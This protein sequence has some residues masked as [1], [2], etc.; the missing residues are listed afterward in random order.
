MPKQIVI[1]MGMDYWNETSEV[2]E[3]LVNCWGFD[4]RH[5]KVVE[6]PTTFED[7]KRNDPRILLEK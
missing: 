4:A 2:V 6:T 1:D 7:C 5:I 3:N